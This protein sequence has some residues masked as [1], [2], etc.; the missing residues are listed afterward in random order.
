MEDHFVQKTRME[1]LLSDMA[2]KMQNLIETAFFAGLIRLGIDPVIED[3]PLMEY[4]KKTE[5]R[6]VNGS[7]TQY[8]YV[9]RGK[10]EFLFFTRWTSPRVDTLTKTGEF[11]CSSFFEVIFDKPTP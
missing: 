8:W 11:R 1:D 4:A 3:T 5:A 10:D 6:Y 7:E 2:S 9:G